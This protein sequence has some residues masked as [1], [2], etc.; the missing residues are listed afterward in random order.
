MG[1]MIDHICLVNLDFQFIGA[2]VCK[3]INISYHFSENVA[4]INSEK[5][6]QTE[7]AKKI[8]KQLITVDEYNITTV[9]NDI[10]IALKTT[11]NNKTAGIDG[12]PRKFWKLVNK[13]WNEFNLIGINNTSVAVP[14]FKNGHFQDQNN[15]RVLVPGMKDKIPELLFADNAVILEESAD[16]LQKLFDILTKWCKR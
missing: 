13:A 15:Y 6:S 2:S 10:T 12:I 4:Y 16:E 5:I 3:N 14:I 7:K 9:Y 11:P 8:D 1:R